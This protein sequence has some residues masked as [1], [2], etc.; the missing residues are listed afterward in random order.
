MRSVG[1]KGGAVPFVERFGGLDVVVGVAEDRGLAGGV[2]PVGVDEGMS[3]GGDD[4]DVFHADAA[5]F[6]GHVVGGFLYVG[7]VFFEGA[8]AGDAEQIF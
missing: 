3:F 2:Q 4:L 7:L 6:V 5:Q 8:Y 1:S